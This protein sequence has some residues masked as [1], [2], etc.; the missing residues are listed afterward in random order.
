MIPAAQAVE[1]LVHEYG[2]LVFHTIYGL[3]GTWEESQDLT[4]DTFHQALKSIDAARAVSG[5]QFNARAWLLRIAINTVR[6]Q[7]RRQRLF[8][9]VPFSRLQ[10]R[11]AGELEHSEETGDALHEQAAPLQPAGYGARESV[12]PGELVTERDAVQRTMLRLPETL[13]VCLLLSV[14]GC[15][16]TAEIAQMLDLNEAAVRQRLA[17]ARKQFQQLYAGEGGEEIS[18]RVHTAGDSHVPHNTTT[19]Y[20]SYEE[21]VEKR[22]AKTESSYT[23]LSSPL[24]LG[25]N[26][27][28][29]LYRDPAAT[30]LW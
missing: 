3:T 4:Q 19:T 29:R 12:D 21:R 28:E 18:D 10:K 15:F 1:A 26:H 22:I 27:A 9:F 17:R 25:R 24:H 20:Q 7:Q 14:I 16:S 5:T 13:R 30:P 23:M 2:K 11:S 6:M 8:R